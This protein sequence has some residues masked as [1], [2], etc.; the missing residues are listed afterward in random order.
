MRSFH[1]LPTFFSSTFV[2]VVFVIFHSGAKYGCAIDLCPCIFDALSFIYLHITSCSSHRK[3]SF[4]TQLQLYFSLNNHAYDDDE[5]YDEPSCYY[6][7]CCYN[8]RHFILLLF[9]LSLS[10]FLHSFT[11]AY[12]KYVPFPLVNLLLYR[13]LSECLN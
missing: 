4:K 7:S 10:L 12:M 1:P 8:S 3:K 13:S 6:N 11:S 2:V 9:S 5:D